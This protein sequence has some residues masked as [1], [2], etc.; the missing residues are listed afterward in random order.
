MTTTV[1]EQ[2]EIAVPTR[3]IAR[4]N[5]IADILRMVEGDVRE[6]SGYLEY[7]RDAVDPDTAELV[8]RIGHLLAVTRQAR[9]ETR[10][11]T[12]AIERRAVLGRL[13]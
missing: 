9:D 2:R 6:I 4:L 5:R 11:A 1:R 7:G 8:R 12:Q 10:D 13:Q 3:R